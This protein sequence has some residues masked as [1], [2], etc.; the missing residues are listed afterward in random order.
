MRLLSVKFVFKKR[1]EK[2]E[3]SRCFWDRLVLLSLTGLD[4][5]LRTGGEKRN[6]A[7]FRLFCFQPL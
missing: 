4:P 3:V 2:D 6:L 1:P 5:C 7:L